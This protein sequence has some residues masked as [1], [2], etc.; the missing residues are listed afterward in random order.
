MSQELMHIMAVRQVLANIMNFAGVVI[1]VHS[2]ADV[3]IYVLVVSMSMLIN[4]LWLIKKGSKLFFKIKLSFDTNLIKNIL[5]QTLPLSLS[6]IV[7]TFM[8]QFG[9]LYLSETYGR[10]E[11]GLFAAAVKIA[12]FAI[13]PVAILQGSFA[14]RIAKCTGL[15]ERQNIA[16]KYATIL[17]TCG[18]IVST[19]M[20]FFPEFVV[21]VSSGADFMEATGIVRIASADVMF[22]YTSSTAITMFFY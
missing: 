4:N 8:D 6:F 12:G 3:P 1:F 11:T 19:T 2:A 5:K 21:Y 10:H 22:Y 17:L 13:I 15:S 18:A 14:P 7:I 9:I 20:F 16:K